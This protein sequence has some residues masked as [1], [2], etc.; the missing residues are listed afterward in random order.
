MHWFQ[1]LIAPLIA[2][3]VAAF[4]STYLT[5]RFSF[6]RFRQEQWWQMKREAYESIIR[7]LSEVMF[8]ASREQR[9]IE[10][11]VD[12]PK[13]PERQKE[14]SWSLKEIAASGAYIVSEKTVTESEKFLNRSYEEFVND[15]YGMLDQ[16]YSDAKTTL[17]IV[18]AESHRELGVEGWTT[19][20]WKRSP[21]RSK[22]SSAKD[23]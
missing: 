19:R 7:E 17:E 1:Y 9:A 22:L 3:A 12:P 21:A 10:T 5:A 15:F 6:K 8:N 4:A 2:G 13:S 18:R 20:R 23:E 16:E 14:R 11:G